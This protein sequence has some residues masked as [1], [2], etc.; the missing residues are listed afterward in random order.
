MSQYI[1]AA[2]RGTGRE[3]YTAKFKEK[4]KA[5]K[6]ASL[7][8]QNNTPLDADASVI[9]ADVDKVEIIG[10]NWYYPPGS[11]IGFWSATCTVVPYSMG[12]RA[13]MKC[14][15]VKTDVISSAYRGPNVRYAH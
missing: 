6:A 12:A 2:R 9:V 10:G 3:F 4:K 14:K 8:R 15:W 11:S 13:S 1:L 7:Y 5:L